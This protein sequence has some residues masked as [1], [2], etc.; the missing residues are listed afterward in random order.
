MS[1]HASKQNPQNQISLI[2]SPAPTHGNSAQKEALPLDNGSRRSNVP[3]DV[4][5]DDTITVP[6]GDIVD[7][8]FEQAEA[9]RVVHATTTQYLLSLLQLRRNLTPEEFAAIGNQAFEQVL[10]TALAAWTNEGNDYAN[11]AKAA[12]ELAFGAVTSGSK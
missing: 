1:K 12:E 9:S 7:F 5:V 10:Q 11:R 3:L 4:D 8:A 6:V 2:S